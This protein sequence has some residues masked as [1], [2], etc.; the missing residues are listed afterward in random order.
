MKK[1]DI[2]YVRWD[3]SMGTTG[4]SEVSDYDRVLDDA[5][6]LRCESVGFL[7]GERPDR[8]L[9][10]LSKTKKGDR[11]ADTITI[12]RAAITEFWVLI[13]NSPRLPS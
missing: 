12:P 8:L 9:L 6:Y 4:W 2:V 3:D 13:D 1:G 11:A 5:D 7:V 10:A